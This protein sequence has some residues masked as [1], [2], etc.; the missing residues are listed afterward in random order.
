MRVVTLGD[1]VVAD[2]QPLFVDFVNTLH[3]YEGEPVELI[4][5]DTDL[6]GWLAECGLEALRLTDCLPEIHRLRDHARAVTEAL[7]TKHALPA[8]DLAAINAVLGAVAGHLTLVGGDTAPPSLGFAT[9]AD[10]AALFAFRVALSIA[11]FLKS[12]NRQRLKLCANP[13]CGFAFLDLSI[14]A[15]RRWCDMRYCGNRLKA[16]AFRRRGRQQPADHP[17]RAR[18]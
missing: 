2:G 13:G 10:D 5:N 11:T 17:A 15:T 16:R 1:H 3:W 12:G 6:A 7:A 9:E 14:N 18:T 4:G 8:E